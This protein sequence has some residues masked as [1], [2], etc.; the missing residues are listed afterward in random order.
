MSK[1]K[2]KTNCKCKSK[3]HLVKNIVLFLILASAL[4]S[5]VFSVLSYR[6]LNALL[7]GAPVKQEQQAKQPNVSI[8]EKYAKNKEFAKAQESGKPAVVLFYVDWCGYCQRFAPIFSEIIKK[9]A[10]KSN[11]SVAFVNCE[12][13][14]NQELMKEYNV[15]AF[16]TLY[17]VDFKSGTKVQVDNNELFGSNVKEALLD[18]FVKFAEEHK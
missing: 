16:P 3:R 1:N 11:L 15:Q 12:D 6:T 4:T 8:T 9:K 13:S 17:M 2:E 7:T 10:F 14:A 18:K 5:A